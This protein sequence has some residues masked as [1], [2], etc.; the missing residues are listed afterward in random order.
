M[1]YRRDADDHVW[2]RL[3][4]RSLCVLLMNIHSPAEMKL[5]LTFTIVKKMV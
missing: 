5:N 2:Y 1:E 3:S 4:F